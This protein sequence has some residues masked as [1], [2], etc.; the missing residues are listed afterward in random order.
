[1]RPILGSA[2]FLFHF[3]SISFLW[4]TTTA[5]T[6]TITTTTT[7]TTVQ[8]FVTGTQSV[9]SLDTLEFRGQFHQHLYVR[10]FRTNV[11]L[12]AFSSYAL[13]LAKNSYKKRSRKMLMKSTAGVNFTREHW[14]GELSADKWIPIF[15]VF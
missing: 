1:M 9:P 6:T 2:S 11:V 4:A 13:A 14:T 3:S 12:A 8:G 5:A 10:I 15:P 7:A